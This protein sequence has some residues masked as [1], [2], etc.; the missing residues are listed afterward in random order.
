MSNDGSYFRNKDS[1]TDYVSK[2]FEVTFNERK[3]NEE[4]YFYSFKCF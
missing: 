3:Y 1:G 4:F 2:N